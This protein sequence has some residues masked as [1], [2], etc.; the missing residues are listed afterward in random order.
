VDVG[1]DVAVSSSPPRGIL[2]AMA[3][4]YKERRPNNKSRNLIVRF[5]NN[6]RHLPNQMNTLLSPIF[7]HPQIH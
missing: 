4:V 1:I 3:A 2:Q 5:E 7:Y 6:M